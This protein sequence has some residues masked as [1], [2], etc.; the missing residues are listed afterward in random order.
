MRAILEVDYVIAWVD[1]QDPAHMAARKRFAPNS[2]R[3]HFEA[4]TNERYL[5]HQIRPVHQAHFHHHRSLK[6]PFPRC[7]Q[8]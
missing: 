2:D 4:V 7:I 3:T 6:A 8:A 1:G 5:R